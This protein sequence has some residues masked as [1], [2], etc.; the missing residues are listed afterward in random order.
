M[1]AIAV[2]GLD[3]SYGNTRILRNINFTIPEGRFAVLLGPN[4]AGK[5]TLL[6]LMLGE[7]P[8]NGQRGRIE[9]LGQEIRQ[10]RD[11]QK[12][13]YVSQNGMASCQ[14]FPA[15]VEELVQV[16]LYAQIGRFRF[17][18]RKE[19]EQV[20]GALNQ[21]GMGDFAKRMIGRL[22]GGQQQR[23]LLARALVNAPRLLLLD[24]P[25]SSMDEDSTTLF[26]RLLYQINREQGVTIWIVTHDR[27]RLMAYADDIWLLEDESLKLVQP[28]RKENNYGNL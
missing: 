17:A 7:L 13:S 9:L 5:S 21:V 12:I 14:S 18:G 20:R 23:V 11:W 27:K 28:G 1:D 2:K 3:F 22:S 15:S 25:T 24:E 26:Y 16:D 10:F 6:K 8:F 4:G 19:K